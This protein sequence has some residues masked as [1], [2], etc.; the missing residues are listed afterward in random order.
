MSW[1]VKLIVV[2]VIGMVKSYRRASQAVVA[3]ADASTTYCTNAI[4]GKPGNGRSKSLSKTWRSEMRRYSKFIVVGSA[5]AALA[6]PSIASADVNVNSNG[7]GTIGKGDVQTALG[8][9][10]DAAFQADASNVKF[11]MTSNVDYVATHY[12]S[13]QSSWSPGDPPMD[14]YQSD[15]GTIGTVSNPVSVTPKITGGKITGYVATGTTTGVASPLDYSQIDWSKWST[16]PTG[17]HFM[18]WIDPSN[19]F[20]TKTMPGALQVSNLTKTAALPNTPVTP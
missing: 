15:M 1:R 10:N 8:Y 12:C 9:A 16:C 17:E 2:R 11:S 5:L 13:A 4:T 19:A 3:S 7:V 14:V 20:S 6:V 18:G